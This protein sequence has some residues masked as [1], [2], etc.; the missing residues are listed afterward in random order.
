MK[1]ELVRAHLIIALTVAILTIRCPVSAADNIEGPLSPH[2]SE[3]VGMTGVSG[4]QADVPSETKATSDSKPPLEKPPKRYV[5][6]TSS[7]RNPEDVRALM[8]ELPGM[9]PAR[10]TGLYIRPVTIDSVPDDLLKELSV[11]GE[12]LLDLFLGQSP[13]PSGGAPPTISDSG[14][15]YISRLPKL[16]A[17]C[18]ACRFS[19]KGFDHLS[20]LHDLQDISLVYPSITAKDFFTVVSRMPKIRGIGV[21]HADFSQPID[22]ATH[23]TIAALNGRLESLSFGEWQETKIHASMIPAIAKIE[24]L[25]FLHLGDVR[26]SLPLGADTYLR[27]LPYLET[28]DDSDLTLYRLRRRDTFPV[29]FRKIQSASEMYLLLEHLLGKFEAS[30]VR[31]EVVRRRAGLSQQTEDFTKSKQ[32]LPTIFEKSFGV[33]GRAD[34]WHTFGFI[35]SQYPELDGQIRRYLSGQDLTPKN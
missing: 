28:A 29:E 7:L 20:R 23:K 13:I 26:G 3:Q 12:S 5:S 22:E 32:M 6:R 34:A 35:Q 1:R 8:R 14:M 15:E 18:L 17:L 10:V 33:I 16:R 4:V 2:R 27:Q 11:Q 31:R 21:A 9:R 30:K 25:T 24:S 19:R